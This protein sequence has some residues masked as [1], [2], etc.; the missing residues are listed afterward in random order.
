MLMKKRFWRLNSIG[1][2]RNELIKKNIF[3]SFFVKGFGILTSLLLVPVT[4]GFLNTSEY[5]IWLTL[6]SI[7]LWINTFDI[8]LGNGKFTAYGCDLGYKYVEINADYRS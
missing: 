3:Y 5:G 8:G 4:I 1:D 2:K 7:L 6:N